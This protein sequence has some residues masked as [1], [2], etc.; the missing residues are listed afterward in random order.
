[1]MNVSLNDLSGLYLNE[2]SVLRQFYRSSNH[3]ECVNLYIAAV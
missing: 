1:V 2:S 3:R